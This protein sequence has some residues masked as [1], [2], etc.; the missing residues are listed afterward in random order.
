MQDEISARKLTDRT[1]RRGEKKKRDKKTHFKAGQADGEFFEFSWGVSR[2]KSG[3]DG[4]W[5]MGTCGEPPRI[6]VP[7]LTCPTPGSWISDHLVAGEWWYGSKQGV[8]LPTDILS[9]IAT[10]PHQP[11]FPSYSQ[12]G[13]Q[14]VPQCRILSRPESRNCAVNCARRPFPRRN[15]CE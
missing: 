10:T 4:E 9:T 14:P 8:Y 13:R 3:R 1:S 6:V 5:T 11:L 7:V 15:I 12:T 2:R